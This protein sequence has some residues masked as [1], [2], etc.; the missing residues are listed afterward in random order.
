MFQTICDL[1]P[2]DGDMPLRARRLDILRRVLNG[3]FYD[4]LPYDFHEE[5]S[6]SGEYIPL[7]LRRPSV[8]YSMAR[9]ITEDSVA[10]L[11]SEGHFPTIDSPDRS[12]RDMLGA[13]CKSTRLNEVMIDAALRGS[14]GSVAILMRV[15]AGRPFFTAL[16]TINLTPI[17]RPDAP[18]T[19][20][21]VTER[22]KLRG[23]ALVTAGYTVPDL[24]AT[25][26]F[27][28]CWN[29]QAETWFLPQSTTSSDPLTPD[30]ARTVK[31]GLGFVPLVWVRNLPGSSWTEDPADGACTF[32]AAIET[33]I[34]IDYQLS[35]AG[36][37]LK[38][39]SDPTLLIKEPAGVEGSLIRGAGN[40]LIVSE[41][42]DAKLLEIG[43]TASAAVIEYVRTLRE[44]ALESVHGNRADASRLSA[45]TSGRAL[46][47]MNQG[48]LWL[49][50]NLRIS[51]GEGALLA[52]ARMVLRAGARYQLRLADTDLPKLDSKAPLSLIWP[53]W[54]SA[55]AEDRQHDAQTLA[56]LTSAGLIS[57][58]TAV[59]SLADTYDIEDI[60]AE[61]ARLPPKLFVPPSK[62]QNEQPVAAR[63]AP[64][65]PNPLDSGLE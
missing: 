55:T 63:P 32:R 7:R 45:A 59:K 33:S 62:S 14:I 16:D 57:T 3:T 25:Y 6:P 19:L 50:D 2:A 49:A 12:I 44:F 64:T 52:L 9:I 17:W 4:A 36:R 35:Q 15:L 38:Y 11:F 51:Y 21:S 56:T 53:R 13:L 42:G 41:H 1:I 58:E 27:T 54:Y 34:E 60:P 29:D 5:R 10:L 48:L 8:R 30:P 37:G 46:E 43:G 23:S 20:A 39:S 26:W 40:A 61:L 28:R 22:Y 47:L 24:G 65:Q 18:D 31:H